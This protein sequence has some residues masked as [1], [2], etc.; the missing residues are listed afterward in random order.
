MIPSINCPYLGRGIDFKLPCQSCPYYL[1]WKN[2]AC[3]IDLHDIE[4]STKKSNNI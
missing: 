4:L 1:P 3:T 2:G